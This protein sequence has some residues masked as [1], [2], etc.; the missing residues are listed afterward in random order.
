MS[1]LN[2][3]R[4]VENISSKTTVYTPIIELIVNSIHAINEKGNSESGEIRVYLKRSPQEEIDQSPSFIE[5]ISVKDNG[6]GFTDENRNSFDTLYSDQKEEIGGKGFGRFTCLKYFE[7]LKVE[8]VFETPK[9]FML[10]KFSMG[11]AKDIIENETT[12]LVTNQT[13]YSQVTLDSLKKNNYLG[14]N[15][16]TI[17][18]NLVEKLLPYFITKNY[19]C[20]RIYLCEADGSKPILLNDYVSDQKGKIRELKL[21]QNE[22]TIVKDDLTRTFELRSFKMYSPKNHVS[23]ISLVADK[24]EVTEASLHKYVPEFYEEFY[25]KRMITQTILMVITL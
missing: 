5:G 16:E 8:S 2:I 12:D 17:A 14:K 18:S 4:T 22:F 11:K 13:T 19:I 10:R 1:S 24:R 15:I 6:I 7:S 9:V 23:K 21:K 20:P 25:D 3:K